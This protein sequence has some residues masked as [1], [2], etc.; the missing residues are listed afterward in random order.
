VLLRKHGLV[1]AVVPPQIDEFRPTP[2]L[3]HLRALCDDDGNCDSLGLLGDRVRNLCVFSLQAVANHFAKTTAR[4]P[5][6]D[7][8][9]PTSEECE[10]LIAYMLSDL[11]ADQ[12]E[13]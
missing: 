8:R 3:V 1:H 10:T 9:P 13:R 4:I 12:D 5:G 7:F 11:V 2:T 6:R